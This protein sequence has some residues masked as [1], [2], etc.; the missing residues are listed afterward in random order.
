MKKALAI[1]LVLAAC[2]TKDEASGSVF[3][4]ATGGS[5]IETDSP[6]ALA[7]GWSV[8]YDRFVVTFGD[9]AMRNGNDAPAAHLI[10]ARLVDLKPT[11]TK[12][13]VSFPNLAANRYSRITY[14]VSPPTSDTD[15]GAGATAE[16]KQRMLAGGYAVLVE[17]TAT[18]GAVTKHFQWGF[19]LDTSY[20]NC[21]TKA[22][23]GGADVVDATATEIGLRIDPLQ[24][25][26]DG[27]APLAAADANGD[28]VI[29][30]A[31]L[32]TANLLDRVRAGVRAMGAFHD[33]GTCDATAN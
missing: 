33:D 22:Q 26:P 2:G 14:R 4:T 32:A 15:V 28:Q 19:G 20:D 16:D 9:L 6:T 31:E 8:H 12:Q 10:G 24:L 25:Y 21:R 7:D 18:S 17:G 23:V 30:L 13:I 5:A 1:G 11:G 29:D 27:F 3:F